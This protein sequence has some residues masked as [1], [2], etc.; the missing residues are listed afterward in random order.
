MALRI[1]AYPPGANDESE[2][3]LAAAEAI[4]S[5]ENR[6]A[7]L[8]TL[9][10]TKFK[11]AMRRAST[12]KAPTKRKPAPKQSRAALQDRTNLQ[13]GSDTEEVEAFN[14]D[15]ME[16]EEAKPKAKRAKTT[17]ASRKKAVASEPVEDAPKPAAAKRTRTTKRAPSAE[18]MRVIPETQQDP[19]LMDDISQS[20]EGSLDVGIAPAPIAKQAASYAPRQRSTSVQPVQPRPSARS[21]S[22]Q[23]G[24]PAPRERSGSVSGTER[25]RRG[26]D[27]ELRRKLNDM[28]RKH[29][30]LSLKYQNLQEIGQN[31]AES[32]FE[33]LKR[34]SDEKAKS[35]NELIASLKKE[36]AEAR[37]SAKIDNSSET[38]AM[39]KQINTLNQE[40]DKLSAE[41]KDLKSQ[42]QTAQSDTKAAQNE[43]K[44]VEAK[45]VAARQQATAMAQETKTN[46]ATANRSL[47]ANAT[48][49][50]KE[51]K[52]REN[53]Y[54]DLTGLI[55]RNV[56]RRETEDEFDCLQTGRNGSKSRPNQFS[57]PHPLTYQSQHFTS[58]SQSPT[59][60]AHRTR[61]RLQAHRMKRLSSPTTLCWTRH[62]MASSWRSCPITLLRV[63]SSRES[64]PPSSTRRC[65]SA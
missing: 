7:T 29:E 23:P 12:T 32:N 46:G 1:S 2:D 11:T 40:N 22:V 21:N 45:L 24:Y 16:M 5:N 56:K 44:A 3:D 35:A 36:L 25:E 47:P 53:L 62:A 4:A 8:N 57:R 65:S 55:I 52:M 60:P 31:S 19:D 39:Q 10:A 61:R 42:V 63:S 54:A 9:K 43:K 64:R 49:A 27:P 51:A 26:G 38:A 6:R 59:R 30:N 28:T 14:D 18:P 48:E 33:K 37:K 20:I 34:A 15:E 41:N 13:N 58:S 50:Q 17:A